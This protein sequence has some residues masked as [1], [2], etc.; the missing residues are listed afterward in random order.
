MG[1]KVSKMKL[2]VNM[3]FCSF[4]E[5]NEANKMAL[6]SSHVKTTVVFV[7][8]NCMI[9]QAILNVGVYP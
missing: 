6:P 5:M 2:L 3:L 9:A 1:R 4:L 7:S 8:D